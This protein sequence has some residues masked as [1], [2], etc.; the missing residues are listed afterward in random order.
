M[1]KLPTVIELRKFQLFYLQFIKMRY[2]YIGSHMGSRDRI[3][4]T[5]EDD[6]IYNSY[7]SEVR[8]S[9]GT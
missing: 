9:H 2:L 3:Q 4:Q 7:S 1:I 6:K 5:S 8:S